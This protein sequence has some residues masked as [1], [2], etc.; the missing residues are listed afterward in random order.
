MFVSLKDPAVPPILAQAGFECLVIDRE[1]GVMGLETAA[2]LIAAGRRAGQFCITRIP[3]LT[4]EA[5]QDALESGSHGVLAPKI[6]T[7]QEAAKLAEWSRYPPLGSRGFHPLTPATNYG[8]I[9]L[10]AMKESVNGDILVGAQIET[11]AGLDN[12]EAIAATAGIDLLFLGPGD[13]ALSMGVGFDDLALDAALKRVVACA[14]AHGKLAGTFAAR[15]EKSEQ[16]VAAGA[17]LIALGIDISL[18]I[19]AGKTCVNDL[20]Q[21]MG[22]P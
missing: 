6:E 1:H 3:A 17:R 15:R 9:D 12:V 20:N 5:V 21:H 18:L 14:S 10:R 19:Q 7:A 13:L 11:A 22:A 2:S 4:R 8:A 16:A